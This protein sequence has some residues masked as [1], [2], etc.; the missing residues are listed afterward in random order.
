MTK[1]SKLRNKRVLVT[2][3]AGFIGSEIVRQLHS[4][5]AKIIV[6]DNYS[7]GRSRY[8]NKIPN[9]SQVRGSVTNL[10]K[11]NDVVNKSD[12]VINLAALPFIPDSFYYPGEFFKVNAEGTIN[13]AMAAIK[14]KRIKGF[15]HISTS[16]VYGSAKTVPMSEDHP[17]LPQST[18]AASKLAGER[19]IFTLHKEHGLPA[20]IIRPF[21]SYGPRITQ[22]YIIPEIISQIFHNKNFVKLGNIESSRD[23]T[24]VSDTAG[25]IISSLTKDKAIG[26]TI[27]VGSNTSYK[28][29]YL[30]MQ[31]AK[32]LGQNVKIK[33]DKKRFR[34]FDVQKLVCDYRKARKL[35][36]WTPKISLDEG[37]TK[38]IEWMKINSTDFAT[39]FEGWAKLYRM[40][41]S[42]K[43]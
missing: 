11:V 12:Y 41:L 3:G 8:I 43:K 40:N 6:F 13:V 24:F 32:S 27:N 16:E 22:P 5:G 30:V 31:I 28:I 25:G 23:F 18:Y 9:V 1:N 39:P 21:N 2:G 33:I 36:D 10:S 38:T 4:L 19:A 15:V 26:E 42:H 7:S 20:V 29:K 35:L 34:P 17:T 14:S 37:L